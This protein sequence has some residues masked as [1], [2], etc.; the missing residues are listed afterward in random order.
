MLAAAR[1]REF[2]ACRFAIHIVRVDVQRHCA[3]VVVLL[4]ANKQIKF[5]AIDSVISC[6][7][8]VVITLTTV[9]VHTVAG[10]TLAASLDWQL[11]E[12]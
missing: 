9:A 5:D 1:A 11:T 8:A 6:G 4:S 7:D 3:F 12:K 2:D 10:D